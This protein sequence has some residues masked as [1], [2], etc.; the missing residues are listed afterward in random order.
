MKI[1]TLTY[2]TAEN[3][4]ALLQAY[5]LKEYLKSEYSAEVDVINYAP[6][7][8]T[9]RYDFI[10]FYVKRGE[11]LSS[12]INA[13]KGVLHNFYY[14]DKFFARKKKMQKFMVDELQ[15]SGI[16]VKKAEDMEKLNYDLYVVGSDQVWNPSI[17]H[18]MDEVFWGK[19]KRPEKSLLVS[20]A[21]SLGKSELNYSD[22]ETKTLFEAFHAISVREK[23]SYEYVRKYYEGMLTVNIDPV[24]LVDRSAW[25]QLAVTPSETD[26]VVLFYTEKDWELIETAQKIANYYGAKLVCLNFSKDK[27]LNSI[28]QCG[29][30]EM[31]GYIRDAK[32]VV[33]NSFH[34][35]AFSVLFEKK[36]FWKVHSQ[37]GNRIVDMMKEFE[38]SCKC[39]DNGQVENEVNWEKVKQ[40]IS[41]KKK[42]TREYFCKSCE[43]NND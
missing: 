35:C 12:F 21:A 40:I 20:Y 8:L 34:G 2:S 36:V 3:Y 25:E 6:K 18:G 42:E 26:Y 33:T 23:S 28:C 31:L 11:W 16:K 30:K 24:F 1:C 7:R 15:L 39:S 32:C 17:T 13:A 9:A 38:I 22:T 5:A 19:F 10:P 4:G 29:P 41:L 14:I 27:S 37:F 43:G